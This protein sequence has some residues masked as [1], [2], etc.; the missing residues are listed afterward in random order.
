MAL[1]RQLCALTARQSLPWL[2]GE[3]E[4]F[5]DSGRFTA[6]EPEPEICED[7]ERCVVASWRADFHPDR[8]QSGRRAVTKRCADLSRAA[9]ISDFVAG[10]LDAESHRV[11]TEA[12]AGGSELA[13]SIAEAE[14]V[15]RRVHG[16]L[17]LPADV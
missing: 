8:A 10:R 15:R 11:V 13:T 9:L 7:E 5:D 1:I 14:R 2:E 12:L 6:T 16:R 17:R 4:L 3:R